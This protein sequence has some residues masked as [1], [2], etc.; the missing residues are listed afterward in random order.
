MNQP[1]GE[2]VLDFVCQF[3]KSHGFPPSVRE[4]AQG[5]GLGSTSVVDYHLSALEREGRIER[6]P[7]IARGLRLRGR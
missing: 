4:I 2:R 5:V 3:I 6:T 7:G 1:T